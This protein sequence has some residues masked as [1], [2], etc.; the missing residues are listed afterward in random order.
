M[1][2][3]TAIHSAVIG[4]RVDAVDVPAADGNVCSLLMVSLMT[5]SGDEM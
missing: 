2:K 5:K 4:D 3:A 1:T